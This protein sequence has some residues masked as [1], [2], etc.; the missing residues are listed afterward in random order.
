MT[1][2]GTCPSCG[3]V[4]D[5]T[6]G[7]FDLAPDATPTDGAVSV[8]IRC[9]TIGVFTGAGLE[10]RRATAEEKGEMLADP[11]VRA[12]VAAVLASHR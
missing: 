12:A 4:T 5:A 7:L 1:A 9:G 3:Y 10:V 11:R 8:C 6:T 2:E